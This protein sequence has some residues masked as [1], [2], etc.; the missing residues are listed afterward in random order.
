MIC[1]ICSKNPAT[2]HVTELLHSHDE[3]SGTS[4]YE[5]LDKHICAP[6][7][8][9]LDLPHMQAVTKNSVDIWKLLQKSTKRTRRDES[10]TCPDC[11]MTLAEFRNRGRLGCPKD[12]EVFREHL[13]G[14]LA[15][16]HNAT[17]HVGRVAG[18]DPEQLERR[19]RLSSLREKLEEAIKEEAYEHAA[20]LRDAIRRMQNDSPS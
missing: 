6:C 18:V 17:E 1:Q 20:E 7:A 11:G 3:D 12:Y 15:R 16:M 14:L 13:D 5:T 8:Q 19:Q 10:L 2:V 4:S 9:T